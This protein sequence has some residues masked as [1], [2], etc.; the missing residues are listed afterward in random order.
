MATK[1]SENVLPVDSEYEVVRP[2]NKENGETT[3]IVTIARMNPPTPGHLLLVKKMILDAAQNNLTQINIILS[4]SVDSDENPLD[5]ETKAYLFLSSAVDRL[6]ESL[7]RENPDLSEKINN[8]NVAILCMN[9]AFE[10]EVPEISS[11]TTPIL[12]AINYILFRFYKYPRPELTLKL[13]VGDDRDYSNFLKPSLEKKLVPVRFQQV[14][15]ERPAMTGY[16]SMNCDKLGELD[17][18]SIP[19]EAMSASLLR[20]LVKC[21]L[22]DQFAKVMQRAFLNESE[23]S[24]LYGLLTDVIK[25]NK[26]INMGGG[27]KRKCTKRKRKKYSRKSKRNRSRKSRR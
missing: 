13:F 10:E 3:I 27:K 9:E 12:K 19:V 14:Q 20:N 18:E 4:H 8:V 15:L 11:K 23:I 16:K 7:T 22:P 1:E 25:E 24:E 21:R 17:V 2:L 5:C 6:Q 26:G